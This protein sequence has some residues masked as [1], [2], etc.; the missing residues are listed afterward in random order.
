MRKQDEPLFDQ[1]GSILMNDE[2]KKPCR[3]DTGGTERLKASHKAF[4]RSIFAHR[5]DLK[6]IRDRFLATQLY[7]AGMLASGLAFGVRP[8]SRIPRGSRRVTF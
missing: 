4:G 1:D 6:G 7:S 2:G 5:K 8:A 3:E